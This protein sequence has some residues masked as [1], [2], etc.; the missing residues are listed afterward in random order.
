MPV[1]PAVALKP[2]TVSGVRT[3]QVNLLLDI[4]FSI[5]ALIVGLTSLLLAVSDVRTAL[6]FAAVTGAAACGLVI[7][8]VI[9][10]I[11]S[12][13]SVLKVHH[14]SYEY[15]PEHARYARRGVAFKWTGTAL[16][17]LAAV[18]VVYL[19]LAGTA[20]F[21]GPGT[22][23][24][25]IYLPLL[26]TAFWTAGVTCKGQMY[27]FMV[28]ALQP[29]HTRTRSDLASVLIPALGLIG[30]ALVTLLTVRIVDVL[31]NPAAI[32]PAE[33]ARLSQM[34]LGAVF[35]PAGFALVAY[36]LFLTVYRQTVERLQAGLAALYQAV[37][38]WPGSVPSAMPS[39]AA[40]ASP[41]ACAGCGILVPPG[42]PLC[43]QCGTPLRA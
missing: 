38:P 42:L 22:V 24:T 16:S 1:W 19:L 30:V 12:L 10:F 13:M 43:P 20:T 21:V 39:P 11:V 34:L 17:T 28:R 41:A 15:G 33:L 2:E 18:L 3:Y 40:P 8:F 5:F 23:P 29:S 32:E 4:V 27:R 9:N 31:G 7:I 36:V 26:V 35:L 25:A 14:G 37:P 6:A